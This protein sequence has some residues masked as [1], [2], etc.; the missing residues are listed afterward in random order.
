MHRKR[1]HTK[2]QKINNG[3]DLV[4]WCIQYIIVLYSFIM[5]GTDQ[6][7][8]HSNS[9]KVFRELQC[10][11]ILVFKMERMQWADV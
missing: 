11:V 2:N 10:D 4:I 1:Y 7:S 8:L 6:I 3:I 5:N 9:S